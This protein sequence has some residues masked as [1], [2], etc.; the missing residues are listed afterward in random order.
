MDSVCNS[1]FSGIKSPL[2]TSK[3]LLDLLKESIEPRL[4]SHG[5]RGFV[6]VDPPIFITLF[7]GG[8]VKTRPAGPRRGRPPRTCSE[9]SWQTMLL[10]L[11]DGHRRG[12]PPRSAGKILLLSWSHRPKAHR[13]DRPR[14]TITD[15]VQDPIYLSAFYLLGIIFCLIPAIL[16]PRR[17]IND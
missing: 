6:L 7:P 8:S 4:A 16:I 3:L 2:S 9:H 1:H 5:L 14:T 11:H 10:S 12:R 17:V 13:R 15:R